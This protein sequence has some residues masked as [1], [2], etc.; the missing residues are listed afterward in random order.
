MREFNL[1]NHH[2]LIASN[3]PTGSSGYGIPKGR[4]EAGESVEAAAVREFQE[5]T[6]ISL[7][8]P[9]PCS[10]VRDSSSRHL[11][12][13]G[14]DEC[15]A[16]GEIEEE[17]SNDGEEGEREEEKEKGRKDSTDNSCSAR[18]GKLELTYLEG[19]GGVRGGQAK[20]VHAFI[21]EGNGSEVFTSCNLITHGFRKGLPENS[22]GRYLDLVQAVALC[23]KNQK[24]LIELYISEYHK[25]QIKHSSK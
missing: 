11:L 10:T 14:R 17:G 2:Y 13:G 4:I 25:Q 19:S 23:H 21:V 22:S 20:P 1:P 15:R 16:R 6:G 24:K 18:S 8:V 7:G 3:K 5:E 9:P 12:G